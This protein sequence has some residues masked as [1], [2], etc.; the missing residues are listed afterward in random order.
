MQESEVR[1]LEILANQGEG[2]NDHR[3]KGRT[4]Q[5]VGPLEGRSLGGLL[6]VGP[7]EGRSLGRSPVAMSPVAVLCSVS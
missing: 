1:D 3:K 7:L 4:M 6:R 5:R 2:G